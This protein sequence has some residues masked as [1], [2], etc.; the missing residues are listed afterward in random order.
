[1]FDLIGGAKCTLPDLRQNFEV[2]LESIFLVHSLSDQLGLRVGNVQLEGTSAELHAS[3]ILRV[4]ADWPQHLGALL[5]HRCERLELAMLV[6]A[7]LF[8]R[9]TILRTSIEDLAWRAKKVPRLCATLHKWRERVAVLNLAA[10]HKVRG[11]A[12]LG[13]TRGLRYAGP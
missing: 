4:E 3:H 5:L 9:E 13:L 6:I 2:L 11:A 1:M 10:R 8:E 12:T 7:G